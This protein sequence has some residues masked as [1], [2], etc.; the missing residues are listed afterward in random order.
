M[1]RISAII[2][3]YNRASYLSKAISSLLFQILPKEYYEIIIIDNSSTDNTKQIVGEFQSKYSNIRYFFEGVQGL[4]AARNRGIK[5]AKSELVAFLDDDAEATCEWLEEFIKAFDMFPNAGCAGGKIELIWPSGEKPEWLNSKYESFFGKLDIGDEIKIITYPETPYG[6]N[7]CIKKEIVYLSGFFDEKLGRIKDSLLSGEEIEFIYRLQKMK[8][9]I[10]IPAA[11][12]Y[13]HVLPY[14]V[15]K[16]YLLDRLY[17]QGVSRMRFEIITESVDKMYL[18]KNICTS[19]TNVMYLFCLI[20]FGNN[21]FEKNL[22]LQ[23]HKG[24]LYQELKYL[25]HFEDIK[26]H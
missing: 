8:E 9:T 19:I 5:E 25:L 20:Y 14:R 21:L 22:D 1:I 2:C 23:Y 3:T 15:S 7:L 18:Y 12:I 24:R 17:W 26:S 13:H 11:K 6:G 16:Q 10:Y 4:S